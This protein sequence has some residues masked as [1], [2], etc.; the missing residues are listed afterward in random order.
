MCAWLAIY[1]RAINKLIMLYYS[2]HPSREQGTFHGKTNHQ[3]P[4][5]SLRKQFGTVVH[6]SLLINLWP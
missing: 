4:F 1:I 3:P 2:D 5:Q 6:L